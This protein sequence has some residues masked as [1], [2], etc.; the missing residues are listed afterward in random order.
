MEIAVKPSFV[1]KW[2]SAI[3]NSGRLASGNMRDKS[4]AVFAYALFVLT[5][6]TLYLRPAELFFWMAEW[7]IYEVLILSTLVLT[8]QSI[9]G[10][11]HWY[12]LQRQP[13]TLCVVGILLAVV[14]SHAQHMYLGGVI[15]SGTLF[16]KTI[17]YYG[18]LVTIVN[19]PSRMRGIMLTVAICAT[20]MVTLC[21]LDFFEIFDFEF[22]QHL[23]DFD[24]ITDD[25]EVKTVLRMRGTGIFQD[26]NDLASVIV[27]AGV[28]CAYFL[29]EKSFAW[30]RFGWLIPMS[31]LLTGLICT[32]SRGG[33]LATA[34]AGLTL[35]ILRYGG[36]VA[37][38]ASIFGACLLP[39]IAGRQTE[40]DLEGGT[41]QD[42]IQLWRDGFD[43]LKSPDLFFGV[44]QSNYAEYAGLVAHNSYI[45]AYVELGVI[46]GTFF[47]GCFF[48]AAIQ[49][50]RMVRIPDGIV[51]E[52]LLRMRPYIVAML[53]GW[54]TSL[55]SLSRCYVVPTYLV[56]GI[57]S[58]YLNLVWIHTQSGEPLIIWNRNYLFRLTACSAATFVGLYVF[59]AIMA[60]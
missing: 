23:D 50:Y 51:N 57:C 36:K 6:A 53:V 11:F 15:D 7:P 54:G 46:G 12:Y 20:T 4:V 43:A 25:E 16:L 60:R 22:I 1:G 21:V 27:L 18:L 38:A 13:I 55:F 42:R 45:H 34:M 24:G 9:Q 8:H 44:G 17:V 2:Q 39:L 33:L 32:K 10:H 35:I 31:M 29:M 3:G 30:L 40:V 28:L 56:F 59:T 47:F 14:A 26:P 19:S 41:G 5:T 58:A 37:V 49:L 48:F 52:D